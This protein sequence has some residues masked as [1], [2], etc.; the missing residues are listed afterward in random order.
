M[1]LPSLPVRRGDSATFRQ[2]IRSACRDFLTRH[3]ALT[4][5]VVPLRVTVL[6]VP[7]RRDSKAKRTPGDVK[8]LDNILMDVLKVAGEELKPHAE[9]WSLA[10]PI[11]YP[12]APRPDPRE[13]ALAGF[14]RSAALTPG[15]TRYSSFTQVPGRRS[16]VCSNRSGCMAWVIS[17]RSPARC[18][19][20]S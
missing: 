4:P 7:P 17:S 6:V 3:P 16:Y 18:D 20:I 13:L 1:E 11:D 5:L 12:G 10:P 9:P 15:H 19:W 8:D 2:G 14:E